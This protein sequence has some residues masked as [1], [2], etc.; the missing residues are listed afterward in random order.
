MTFCILTIEDI[1]PSIGKF[2][3]MIQSSVVI[4][5]KVFSSYSIIM[6]GTLNCGFTE[7]SSRVLIS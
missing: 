1:D 7:T 5:A 2:R 3:N 6:V 4:P